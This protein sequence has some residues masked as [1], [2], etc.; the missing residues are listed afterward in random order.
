MY[1]C[2]VVALLQSR[3][4]SR[5]MPLL[6]T[7]VYTSRAQPMPCGWYPSRPLHI[8]AAIN[9]YCPLSQTRTHEYDHTDFWLGCKPTLFRDWQLPVREDANSF[10]WATQVSALGNVLVN[11]TALEEAH[12]DLGHGLPFLALTIGGMYA[13]MRARV[14]SI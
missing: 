11:I 5:V 9:L 1:V 7:V 8:P 13:F 10:S 3:I 14:Y 2:I 4:C 6:F 12:P